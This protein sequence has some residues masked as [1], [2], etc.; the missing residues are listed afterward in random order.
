MQ[1]F[2]FHTGFSLLQLPV[3]KSA[4]VPASSISPIG[5]SFAVNFLASHFIFNSYLI[6]QT[7]IRKPLDRG[8]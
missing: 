2:E 4:A 3:S 6:P 8:G 5:N 7:A 1:V